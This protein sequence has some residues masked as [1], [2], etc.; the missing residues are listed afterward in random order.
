MKSKQ[1][2]EQI[3]SR[4]GT[5]RYEYI[6]DDEKETLR[7]NH[8]SLNKG[9]ELTLSDILA[10]YHSIK[11]KAI[12]EVV[13]TIVQTFDAMEKEQ[14]KGSMIY[15]LCTLLLGPLLFL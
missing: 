12:D 2:V 14:K 7:L 3:K 1:L 11:E 6:F 5:E 13:Y 4:L 8:K 15:P 10:K 9:M